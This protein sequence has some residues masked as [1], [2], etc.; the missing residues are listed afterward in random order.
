MVRHAVLKRLAAHGPVARRLSLLATYRGALGGVGRHD[1]DEIWNTL[2]RRENRDQA[3]IRDYKDFCL[4]KIAVPF[5]RPG[6]T[7][8][9]L[10]LRRGEVG[11]G[12]RTPNFLQALEI[13]KI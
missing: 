1:A 12:G 5:L 6:H 8:T 2:S 4:M 11:D 13:V 9:E 10:R 7:E 3:E